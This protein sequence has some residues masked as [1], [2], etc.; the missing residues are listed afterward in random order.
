MLRKS[1]S[2]LIVWFDTAVACRSNLYVM[3]TPRSRVSRTEFC[4]RCLSLVV[5]LSYVTP[6]ILKPSKDGGATDPFTVLGS[7]GLEGHTTLRSGCRCH[8]HCECACDL[9]PWQRKG[10]DRL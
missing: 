10:P 8:R 5:E 4:P 9:V 7:C 1:S 3:P 2:P 6:P